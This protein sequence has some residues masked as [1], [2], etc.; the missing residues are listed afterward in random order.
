MR[1]LG[2]SCPTAGLHVLSGSDWIDFS[3]IGYWG[4]F[5]NL[6]RNSKFV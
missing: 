6:T 5:K 3:D 1:L 2:L 4:L